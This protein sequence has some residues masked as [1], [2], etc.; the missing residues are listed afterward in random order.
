MQK[1]WV[2]QIPW[3][4]D[5]MPNLLPPREGQPVI[6]LVPRDEVV[7]ASQEKTPCST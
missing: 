7:A 1:P 3:V 5:A 4:G 6:R 2:G